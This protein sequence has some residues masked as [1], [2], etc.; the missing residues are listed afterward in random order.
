ML[1]PLKERENVPRLLGIA[2]LAERFAA[3]DNRRIRPED[4]VVGVLLCHFLGL[5]QRIINHI[6]TRTSP[7]L[8]LLDSGRNRDELRPDLAQERAAARRRRCKNK[9]SSLLPA[10]TLR[11]AAAPRGHSKA[12][13]R[14]ARIPSARPS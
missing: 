1:A 12:I 11:S 6:V 13:S 7:I 4:G 2:R 10:D 8:A 9:H 5:C 14:E 3:E